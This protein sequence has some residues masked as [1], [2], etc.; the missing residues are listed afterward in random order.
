LAA[1]DLAISMLDLTTLEGADS[2][3]ASPAKGVWTALK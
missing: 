2:R 1:I 3:P